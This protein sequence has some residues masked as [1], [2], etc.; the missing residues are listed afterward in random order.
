MRLPGVDING[1]HQGN[2]INVAVM[3]VDLSTLR[4]LQAVDGRLASLQKIMHN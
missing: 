1:D 3:C 4:N 2:F